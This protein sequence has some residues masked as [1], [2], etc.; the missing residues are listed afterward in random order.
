MLIASLNRTDVPAF[1]SLAAAWIAIGVWLMTHPESVRR[2]A[3]AL[4]HRGPFNMSSRAL[5][6]AG[7][8]VAGTGGLMAVLVYRSL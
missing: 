5:R 4:P 7:A 1:A 3:D 6:V 8:I 2:Y